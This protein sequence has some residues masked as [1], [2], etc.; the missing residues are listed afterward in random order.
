MSLFVM[1]SCL[2]IAALWSPAGK[3]CLNVFCHFPCGILGQLWYLIVSIPDLCRL[4]Y[5]VI[6]RQSPRILFLTDHQYVARIQ[7]RMVIHVSFRGR[8]V[9]NSKGLMFSPKEAVTVC[10]IYVTKTNPFSFSFWWIIPYS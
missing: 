1:L 7:L 10:T 6:K 9:S 4:S 5:F 8:H 3:G 2:F